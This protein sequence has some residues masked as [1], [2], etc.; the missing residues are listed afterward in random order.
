MTERRDR[1]REQ[2][3]Y[4]SRNAHT[5]DDALYVYDRICTKKHKNRQILEEYGVNQNTQRHGPR[6]G[7]GQLYGKAFAREQKRRADEVRRAGQA[8]AEY[9]NR[10][11]NENVRGMGSVS[12]SGR[13]S[14]GQGRASAGRYGAAAMAAERER[15]NPFKFIRDGIVNMF[16]SIESRGMRD[17]EAAKEQALARKRFIENR[18]ALFT[19][20]ILIL[21]TVVF[22]LFIYFAFFVIFDINVSGSELYDAESVISASGIENGDN[23]YSFHA[24]K[25]EDAITFYCPYIKKASISRTIPNHVAITLEDD[26]ARFYADIYGDVVELSAGLRVLGQ[27]DEQSAKDA[28]LTKLVLPAVNYSVAG[29]VLGFSDESDSRYINAVL[30]DALKSTLGV[31]YGGR[32]RKIDLT[33][34]YEITMTCDGMYIF[35]IGN[36]HDCEL[37]LRM[38]YKTI[39]DSRFDTGIPAKIDVSEVGEASIRYDMRLVIDD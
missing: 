24:G 4:S 11:R 23:L 36:E 9:E 33:S 13:S 18:H 35:R 21:V 1:M 27:T 10:G 6:N 12:G 3:D 19:A 39:T 22:F 16:E 34:E 28:G 32:I 25:T 20:L 30:G 37:K 26:S 38:A 8:R 17:E 5:A 2:N 7:A 14:Y 31:G 15:N 29:R